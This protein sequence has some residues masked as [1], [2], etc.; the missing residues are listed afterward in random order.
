[1]LVRREL[2]RIACATRQ[3][4]LADIRPRKYAEWRKRDS[5]QR[6]QTRTRRF[7]FRTS[8][9]ISAGQPA[10]ALFVGLE[11]TGLK[12]WSCNDFSEE[13]CD[14]SGLGRREG[15]EVV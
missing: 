3:Q 12:E 13:V 2:R 15:D 4:I 6:H 11:S 14:G 7:D 9:E 10:R 1:M 5:P 8:R